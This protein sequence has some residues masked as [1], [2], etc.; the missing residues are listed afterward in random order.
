[1][2]RVEKKMYLT[3]IKKVI[4]GETVVPFKTASGKAKL[5]FEI[6]ENNFIL[7]GEL[8]EK[9]NDLLKVLTHGEYVNKKD[10][11]RILRRANSFDGLKQ[12]LRTFII[13]DNK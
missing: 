6:I 8:T 2:L 9:I 4:K 5:I 3:F 7:K 10:I 1:M 12:E 11:Q 13:K